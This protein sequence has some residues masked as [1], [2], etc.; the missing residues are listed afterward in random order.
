M[1]VAPS[2]NGAVISS[3]LGQDEIAG[4]LVQRIGR[5][6]DDHGPRRWNLEVDGHKLGKGT[7]QVTSAASTATTTSSPGGS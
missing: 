4:I 6:A 2:G 1:T 3:Q 5:F 7:Y